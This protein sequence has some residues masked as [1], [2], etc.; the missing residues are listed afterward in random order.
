MF[1]ENEEPEI[2]QSIGREVDLIIRSSALS[3]MLV[4]TRV[5]LCLS[6]VCN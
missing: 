4:I 2:V 6:V 5:S 3:Q 1:E